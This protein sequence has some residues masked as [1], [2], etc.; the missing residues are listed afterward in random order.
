M[1]QWLASAVV[2]VLAGGCMGTDDT[3][4][5]IAEERGPRFITLG[6]DALGTAQEVLAA[7]VPGARLAPIAVKNDIALVEFDAQDFVALSEAMHEQHHRC[8][9]FLR[10]G[11]LDEGQEALAAPERPVAALTYS[12]DNGATVNV[13]MSELRASSILAT[14]KDL[15]GF[16]NRFFRSTTGAD[17]SNFIAQRWRALA[18][19]RPDVKVTQV[20][21]ADF[22]QQSVILEIPGTTLASEVVVLGA[23]MDSIAAGGSNS[24]APGADDDASGI[25]TLTEIVHA[26]MVKDY[27][28]LRTIHVMA[29]A[30]E[31]VG[32]VG[33]QAI[34]DDYKA[35]NVNVVG[36][37]QL[38]MTNF[39]GSDRDIWL[40]QDF[41]NP[42]QNTFVE[43]LID[44]YTGATRGTDSCGYGCSDHASWHEAGF[45]ASMPFESRFDDFNGTIHTPG[46]T[47]EVSDNNADH[48]VKFARLGVA[49]AAELAKGK[50]DTSNE[51][52]REE[53][54]TAGWTATGLW[55]RATSSKCGPPGFSSPT[56]AMY[57]GQD[58]T[59]NFN[60]GARVSGTMTSPSIGGL[61]SASTLRF[62]FFRDVQK[63]NISTNDV[64]RVSVI[65]G[66]NRTVVFSRSSKTDSQPRWLLSD[67]I[68]LAAFAGKTIQL[69]FEFDSI[70][71]NNNAFTGWMVDDVVVTH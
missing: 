3:S 67:A 70:T 41:T 6:A 57:F 50:V 37:M 11:S 29:Y 56:H 46:D 13:L 28:P 40:M 51:L 68:S 54:E 38:D 71:A 1:R 48:A 52:L 35:R 61:T 12:I 62:R 47:L 25:A 5:T 39:V 9:G 36:V 32:L 59:C 19:G 66:T 4:S 60:T 43:N 55:H 30:A 26:L 18:A 33:S 69:R 65:E 16:K 22:N 7:R 17:A 23:H 24:T 21:H 63:T 14:I 8:S 10:H 42:G 27:H 45:P 44:K 64:V 53:F 15:S 2:T 34:V 20:K 49:F 58:A 31:E